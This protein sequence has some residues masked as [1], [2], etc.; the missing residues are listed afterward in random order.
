MLFATLL[1]CPAPEPPAPDACVPAHDVICTIIGTGDIGFNGD[2]LPADE[3][4][5]YLPSALAWSPNGALTVVDY[6]NMRVRSVGKDGRLNTIAGSGAHDYSTPGISILASPLENPI[7]VLFADD[8]TMFLSASHEARVLRIGTDQVVTVYAGTGE[9]GNSGDGGPASDATFSAYLGGIALG[10]DG[11][12]YIA[13][14][15]NNNIRAV[16]AAGMIR[17][18]PIQTQAPQGLTFAGSALYVA[19]ALDGEIRAYSPETELV[20]TV[21]AGLQYPWGVTV[22]ED[23]SLIIADSG[24]NQIVRVDGESRTV[25]AG[26]GLPGFFGDGDDPLDAEL[27]FPSDILLSDDT[28]YFTDMRNAVVRAF[29]R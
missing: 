1:A 26:T 4:W 3:S 25:L 22:A 5:L 15:F 11:T 20:K 19:S 17:T 28:I 2:S 16:D 24:H 18:L 27:S 13:D 8:G 14:T 10:D 6:N 9:E 12:L 23:G 29:G 21:A 7:D